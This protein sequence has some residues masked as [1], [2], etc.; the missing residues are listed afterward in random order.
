MERHLSSSSSSSSHYPSERPPGSKRATFFLASRR[1]MSQNS[2]PS[3]PRRRVPGCPF[4]VQGSPFLA[5]AHSRHACA[6]GRVAPSVGQLGLVGVISGRFVRGVHRAVGCAP[7]GPVAV[8]I[9]VNS[10]S[11]GRYRCP[12]RTV[13]AQAGSGF[14]LSKSLLW[15]PFSPRFDL[16]PRMRAC[17]PRLPRLPR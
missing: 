10:S 11:K 14:S 17:R 1:P 12:A 5:A 15:G 2:S 8:R 9:R 16:G 6:C 13:T 4:S 3:A 7:A